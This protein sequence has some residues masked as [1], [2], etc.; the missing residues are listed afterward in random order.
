MNSLRLLAVTFLSAVAGN[1]WAIAPYYVTDLGTVPGYNVF[2][3]MG[4]SS[5]GLVAYEATLS[6]NNGDVDRAF[7]CSGGTLTDL[8]MAAGYSQSYATG[9]NSSGQVV[10]E[11]INPVSGIYRAFLYGSGAMSDLGTL[12]GAWSYATGINDSGQVVGWADTSATQ[13][14][15]FYSHGTMTDLGALPGGSSFS[16]ASAINAGG[17]VVGNSTVTGRLRARLPL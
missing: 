11:L 7:L 5:N 14:A 4:I 6:N 16:G 3:G 2:A 13:H 15:F 12:G 9:V 1:A 10:G 8:G 17:Q